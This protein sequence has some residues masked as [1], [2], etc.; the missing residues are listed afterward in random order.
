MLNP[1]IE[2]SNQQIVDTVFRVFTDPRF[3]LVET[4]S[5]FE[6]AQEWISSIIFKLI[7]KAVE[8][9][10]VATIAKWGL[11]VVAAL[12]VARIIY[13]FILNSKQI[14]FA[15]SVKRT[16]TFSKDLWKA[17]DSLASEGHYI[18]ASHAL[19]GAILQTLARQNRII[20]HDSKTAGDYSR[21]LKKAGHKTT[22][23]AFMQFVRPFQL[24]VFGL[25]K[26][27]KE[28]YDQLNQLAKAVIATEQS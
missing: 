3:A 22:Q 7:N 19:Y 10:L 24:V 18:D 4:P 12:I 16:K 23:T 2:I 25:R 5:L 17:A 21:E 20:I 13:L 28:T 11:I 27:T 26:C 8:Y 14:T 9:P 1:Q 6:I 15:Q